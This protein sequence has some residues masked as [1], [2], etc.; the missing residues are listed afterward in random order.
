[1]RSV[2]RGGALTQQLLA[3]SRRQALS[4]ALLSPARLV[5]GL[6]ELLRSSLGNSITL[7]TRCAPDLWMTEADPPQLENAILNL[8]LNARDSMRDGGVLT[9]TMR[10]QVVTGHDGGT[11]DIEP[12]EYVVL[13]VADTGCGM[14]PE[15]RAA[16]FE[17]FFTTKPVGQGTGLGLSQVYGFV[18]QSQGHVMLA[19]E[20]GVGTTISLFLRRAAA[21]EMVSAG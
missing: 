17:P 8:V 2:N 11:A 19:S 6:I 21:T 13:E 18:K 1:M 20:P 3:F 7:T 16:A 9:L 5:E 15:I 4:P 10:N 14:T 12:G